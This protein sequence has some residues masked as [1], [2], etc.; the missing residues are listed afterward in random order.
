MHSSLLRPLIASLAFS[1]SLAAPAWAVEYTHFQPDDSRLEF[2]YRQMGVTLEGNFGTLQGE[3]H[4]NPD[5]PEAASARIEVPVEQIDT[6]LPDANA[7]VGKPE[8][9]AV[10][11]HPLASFEVESVTPMGD[12]QFD[13]VGTLT[14]KGTS[15]AVT[16]PATF[17]GSDERG[18][19]QGEFTLQR[20]DFAIG[21]GAWASDD[22]VANEVDVRFELVATP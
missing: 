15:Q 13:V 1:A 18:V 12:N 7:E 8:W 6:G 17:S 9:F 10:S 19:F 4:F 3:L 16:V 11:D 14:I 2:T 5:N 20:G 21:E 22:V